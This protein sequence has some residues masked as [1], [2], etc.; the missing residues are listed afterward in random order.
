MPI[1]PNG[2]IVGGLPTNLV[3]PEGSR[4]THVESDL[5]DICARLR[6][7]DG[8]LRLCLIE[9]VDGRAIWSVNEITR[10][11]AEELI[12]R[13]GPGCELEELDARVITK[14][15]W[16]RRIPAA[17]RLAQIEKDIAIERESAAAEASERLYENMGSKFY[18]DLHRLG[19]VQG[20]RTESLN[21]RNRAAQRAG[22]RA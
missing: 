21:K 22:R 19:F 1:S 3:L 7:L 18:S 17:E 13:I 12:F 5:H 10:E 16:I 6:E 11:G 15:E 8:N 14:V 4:A 9:H 20:A 2:L